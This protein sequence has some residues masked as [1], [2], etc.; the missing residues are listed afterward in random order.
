MLKKIETRSIFRSKDTRMLNSLLNYRIK[1]NICG[2]SF[3]TMTLQDSSIY[4]SYRNLYL[5]NSIS[6]NILR[7]KKHIIQLLL[8][9][10]FNASMDLINIFNYSNNQIYGV[11]D[12]LSDP[13]IA[14]DVVNKF[15]FPVKD[16][17]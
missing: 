1:Y 3:V 9:K 5:N 8:S 14:A 13:S 4:S 15:K 17:R 12:S 16:F 10:K 6:T 7:S 11:I 2:L